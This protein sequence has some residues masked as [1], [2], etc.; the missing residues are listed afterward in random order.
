MDLSKQCREAISIDTRVPRR[1]GYSA[2]EAKGAYGPVWA[3]VSPSD[4]FTPSGVRLTAEAAA[5][6]RI[7]WITSEPAPWTEP[8][9]LDPGEPMLVWFESSPAPTWRHL[10]VVDTAARYSSEGLP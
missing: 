3:W 5:W 6:D 2:H 4:E 9:D 10:S 7:Q 1:G 8:P